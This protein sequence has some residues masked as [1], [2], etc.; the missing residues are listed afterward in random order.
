MG[1]KPV[2]HPGEGR[3]PVS[4]RSQLGPGLRRES[5]GENE[6]LTFDSLAVALAGRPVLRDVTAAFRPGRVTAIL[7][8]NGAGKSTLV[9]AAAALVAPQ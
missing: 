8:P 7:G 9:K 5:L 2:H 6:A 1:L 4:G 3:A